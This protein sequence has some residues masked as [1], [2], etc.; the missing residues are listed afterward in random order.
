M[1]TPRWIALVFFLVLTASGAAH[2]ESPQLDVVGHLSLPVGMGDVSVHGNLVAVA[3][4]PSSGHPRSEVQLIDITDPAQPR[5][6]AT[7]TAPRYVDY[8]DP[9]LLAVETPTFKG[10]LLVVGGYDIPGTGAG[11]AEFWDVRNPSEPHLLGRLPAPSSGVRSLDLIRREG[12]LYALLAVNLDEVWVVDATDLARPLLVSIWQA[13]PDIV[14]NVRRGVYLDTVIAH[15]RANTEGTRA[16]VTTGDA[17]TFIVDL[18]DLTQPRTLGRAAYGMEDEG[19]AFDAVELAGGGVLVTTDRDTSVEPA[20]VSLNVLNPS[21]LRYVEHAI[22]PDFTQQLVATGPVRGEVVYVGS[23]LPGLPLLADPRGKIA[24]VDPAESPDIVHY[25]TLTRQMQVDQARRLQEAGAIGVLFAGLL[26]R[27]S[28]VQS[29]AEIRGTSIDRGLADAMRVQ[30]AA[31]KTVEV[32]MAAGPATFGFVRFWDLRNIHRKLLTQISAFETPATRQ[33]PP[34]GSYATFS[35]ERLFAR[36]N[37]L[38]VTWSADG[39]RV[40]DIADPAQP[41]EIGHFIPPGQPVNGGPP[42]AYIG[43]VVEQNGLLFASGS[44]SFWIL[45]DVPR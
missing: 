33:T 26:D 35:A 12:R 45:R 21:M 28:G 6:G 18:A 2:A 19:N 44:N 22:E 30:L 31:G 16:Y 42:V 15:V 29:R 13:D 36:G 37:R 41:R 8:Q 43:H 11:S 5:A 3:L 9:R 10:D 4:G 38:Y 23:A 20:G 7:V 17:G 27:S 14:R 25:D 40:L 24:L 34:A 1:R 39:V 32:E